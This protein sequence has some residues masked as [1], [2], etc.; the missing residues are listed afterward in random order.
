MAEKKSNTTYLQLEA[1]FEW[2]KVFPENYDK[3]GPDGAY[4]GH[5]GAYTVD[6]LLTDE[7]YEKLT[8]AGSQKQAKQTDEG[9]NRIKVIRKHTAPYTY[10]G[11]PQVAHVDGTPWD[12]RKDGLI[13][14]GSKGIAY[15]SVYKVKGRFGTRLD[16]LQIMEHVALEDDDDAPRGGFR[17]PDRS[18][19][20]AAPKVT[21][22]VEKPKAKP[23]KQPVLVDDEIPF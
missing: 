3:T 16:G 12:I 18:G 9:L 23:A 21:Q 4:E 11:A 19:Q 7:E 10:G 8:R 17:I 13:G 20:T 15:V 22:A 1:V 5:D 2:A 6:L 14:N